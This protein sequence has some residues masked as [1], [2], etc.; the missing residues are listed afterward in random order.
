[1]FFAPVIVVLGL[2][3]GRS[4]GN[5]VISEFLAIN[6]LVR[7]D[8]DGEF[9]DWIELHNPTE[10]AINLDG[11][12]LTDDAANLTHWRLPAVNLEAGS[13]LLVF[14][15][16][17]DRATAGAEL[18]T[19]FRLM[20]GGE[21]LGL[22]AP[23]GE[24]V[25][26]QFAPEYPRQF[27]DTSYGID[28]GA[29]AVN[30]QI[31][32]TLERAARYHVPKDGEPAGGDWRLPGFD[33]SSWASGENP[34][35]FGYPNQ[36]INLPGDLSAT[37]HNADE[38]IFHGGV[39][40]RFPFQID[41]PALVAGMILRMKYD[42]GFVAYLNGE[43]L[44]AA[45]APSPAVFNST[46]T[47]SAQ[48][49]DDDPFESFVL[50]FAGHLV[51]GA[52]VL[53][54][55]GLN[56]A[57]EDPDFLILPELELRV[58]DPT[59]PGVGYFDNPTPG[60]P[61]G[62]ALTGFIKDTKFSVDRGFFDEAFE[63]EITTETPGVEIRFTTDGSEPTARHGTIYSGP[64]NIDRTTV[65]QAAAFA[66]G[67]RPT[68]VDTHTY[69]FIRLVERQRDTGG[70]YWDTQMD[71]NVV[72]DP[73]TFTVAEAL[74]AIP[75]L[76]IVMNP[77]DLFGP[78]NGIYTHATQRASDNPFW[79]KKCSAEYFFHPDYDGIY[80]IGSGFQIDCGIAINGNFSRLSHNPKHSF[81][82]KFKDEYGPAKLDYPLFPNSPVD[83]YDTVVIRTGH[84]QG[85]ASNHGST[86]MLRN[87]YARDIQGYD[88]AQSIADGNH[89]H[90][91]LNGQYWGLYNFHERPDDSFGAEHWG[92]PKED[93]DGF[94]G[95]RAGG[96][97][98]ARNIS[99]DRRSWSRMFSRADR[100]MRSTDNYH[101][102][103]DWVDVDQLID[104]MIG[105]LYT[106]DRDGPTGIYPPAELPKNFYAVRRRHPEGRFRFFRWDSEFIFEGIGTDMSERGGPENPAGL[107]KRLR[108][109]PEYRLRFADRV[110]KHFFNRGGFTA[111]SQQ[112]DYL[113]RAEQI[114][115][116]MVAESA[117]WG[118]SK[119][120]PPYTRDGNWV[121]ERDRIA[122]SWMPGRHDAIIN[123]F[124][125]DD[126]YPDVEAPSFRV[127]GSLKHGG[128][129]PA[130]ASLTISAPQGTIYFT[131]DGSDPRLANSRQETVNHAL[132]DE[133]ASKRAIMPTDPTNDGV[134]MNLGFDDAAWPAGT[135][136]AGYEQNAGF[137]DL[138]DPNLDFGAQVDAAEH[139]TIYLRAEF[140]LGDPSTFDALTLLLRYDDGFVAY[141]NG[142]EI[143]RARTL[144]LPGSP[145]AFDSPASDEHN[146]TQAVNFQTIL[147]DQHV[148]LLRAGRNILAVHGLNHGLA[149]D[150]FLL[151]PRLEAKEVTGGGVG[152]VPSVSAIEYDGAITLRTPGPVKAR[153]L[154]NGEWSALSD[155]TFL[156]DSER[157]TSNN[158]AIAELHYRPAAPT[159]AEDAE[160]YDKRK[161]FEW[162]EMLNVGPRTV[163]LS[164]VSF[165]GGIRFE[166]GRRSSIGYLEPGERLVVVKNREAFLFRHPNIDPSIIAGEYG[167]RLSDDGEEVVLSGGG[168]EIARFTYNDRGGWP[169]PADGD[170]PSLVLRKP[171]SGPDLN[172]PVNWRPSIDAGGSPG[173]DDR[174]NLAEWLSLNEFADPHGD[175]DGN[176]LTH[177]MNYAYGGEFAPLIEVRA[178]EVDGLVEDYL[179]ISYREN[180]VAEDIEILA[181]SSGDLANWSPIDV[182][183]VS[184]TWQQDGTAEIVVRDLLPLPLNETRFVRL[185]ISITP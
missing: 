178:L 47:V 116:A 50:D 79:E 42:D 71:P 170:G 83:E 144:G 156:V 5:P 185:N 9:S 113:A 128:P 161:D 60:A 68:N 98:Q 172:D 131:A 55:H 138:I 7:T 48:V 75:T 142:V 122:R 106:G 22:V 84:N 181:E 63:L 95:L 86:Q 166:F 28:L 87:Q 137:A 67:F 150:D 16:G 18:H 146:D 151:W 111:R 11:Y 121:P 88:P 136:G 125:A 107:H 25:L 115:V 177:F 51:A 180:G 163:D 149:S 175:P 58:R 43:R 129:V 72:G 120:E 110:Q 14:A 32:I 76:S 6:D 44:A 154:H 123:Q 56:A 1:L 31:P 139:E 34:F 97:S 183:E 143:A 114:S 20:G 10:R 85:W 167:L 57:H 158:L 2:L 65:L 70:L 171:E 159:E 108:A 145:V 119:R 130:D 135:K 104:F 17:K 82:L 173:S 13:Y 140:D 152:N 94:K 45:N 39:Y 169:E 12:Y 112:R 53:A 132:V 21:F 37:M 59:Q 134:W 117:R 164:E 165:T 80:R 36:P 92:G 74:A 29:E 35:G 26:S 81:R 61:N 33:D 77:D 182:V 162:V 157:A 89:I 73:G 160:D 24:T 49:G 103:L 101:A 126:L 109:N 30:T 118:D 64:I 91:Y 54:I 148:G 27:T 99:G 66:P 78:A 102:V 46:A 124:K 90:L 93:Y 184:R 4:P 176:G 38:G 147:V 19:N 141:L 179:T 15:S 105:I 174:T 127:N 168:G 100:D 41:D 153:A 8:G 23:D 40:L 69:L 155:A 96:S 52:N 62:N 133:F 3:A